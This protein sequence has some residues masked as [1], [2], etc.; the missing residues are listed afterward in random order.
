[1]KRPLVSLLGAAL[2][3]LTLTRVATPPAQATDPTGSPM[4]FAV[5][6]MACDPQDPKFNGGDGTLTNC[7][8]KR[9]SDQMVND[10]NNPTPGTTYDAV[11]GLGD[12]QYSCGDPA[13]WQMSYNPTYG[14]MDS[15]M[16]PSV[17]NHEYNTGLDYYGQQCPTD[18]NVAQTY[19]NHFGP[20]AHP[21]ANG[22]YSIDLGSWHLIALNAN[23]TKV[24]AGG[25]SATSAQTAW[26]KADLAST[27]RPCVMAFWHQPRWTGG[28]AGGKPYG[29]W[30]NALYKYHA[31]VVLNGH[32]HDYQRY[33]ALNPLGAA[34]PANG[35][36]EYVVGTGGEKLATV[37]AAY[38]PQPVASAS[39]FGYLRMT[40][41]PTG[42][43]AEFVGVDSTGTAAVLDTSTGTCHL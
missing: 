19:F 17:G 41:L 6:D 11:L 35:V 13:D 14:R 38:V 12:Y 22:H 15:M 1:M 30:W 2:V 24:N 7:A 32:V 9:V 43:T 39:T 34:D 37:S 18:N 21:E 23:C 4:I 28:P 25:C 31:D 27:T 36:T 3:T 5:G 33:P 29:A 26:L 10:I 16:D 8:E 42:W 40:L 20:A